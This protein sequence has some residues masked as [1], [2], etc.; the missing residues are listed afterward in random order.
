MEPPLTPPLLNNR[1]KL[2][3]KLSSKASIDHLGADQAALRTVRNPLIFGRDGRW[4]V[5]EELKR[6]EVV[7]GCLNSVLTLPAAVDDDGDD[8]DDDDG[9]DGDDADADELKGRTV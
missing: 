6:R 8:D 3:S 7:S 5:V 2:S 4:K 1:L 9:G